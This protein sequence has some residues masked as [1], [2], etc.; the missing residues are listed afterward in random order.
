MLKSSKLYVTYC[1]RTKSNLEKGKPQQLYQ[2]QRIKSFFSRAPPGK[3]AILSYRYGI[4]PES[5][6][7]PN[8]DQETFTDIDKAAKRVRK[9][10]GNKE[11]IFYSP[12]ELTE[13]PWIKLLEKSGVNYRVVRSSH[14]FSKVSRKNKNLD[15]FLR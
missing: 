4:V 13:T 7:I 5:R 6:I 14:D 9:V 3:R 8:Y 15:Q 10:V 2:C 11:V 1:S 12:R